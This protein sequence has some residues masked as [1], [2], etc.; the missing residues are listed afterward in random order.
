MPPA[1]EVPFVP[2]NVLF[3]VTV[4][5]TPSAVGPVLLLPVVLMKRLLP[6]PVIVIPG[7]DTPIPVLL[8]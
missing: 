6:A 1:P 8:I 7:R 3:C 2:A 4:I 5:C